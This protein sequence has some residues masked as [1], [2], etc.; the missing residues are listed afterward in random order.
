MTLFKEAGVDAV[1]AGHTH[2]DYDTEYE[3]I[4][5]IA[6]NPVCNPLGHGVSGFNVVSVYK[7]GF[8]VRTVRTTE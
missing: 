7:D 2:K 6:A 8:E 5:S 4:R 1:L 3:G